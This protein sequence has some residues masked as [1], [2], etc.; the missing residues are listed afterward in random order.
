MQNKN[1]I[2]CNE[3]KLGWPLGLISYKNAK[4]EKSDF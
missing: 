1:G 3:P 4:L 2:I